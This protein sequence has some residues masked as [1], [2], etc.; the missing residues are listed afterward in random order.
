MVFENKIT[1]RFT[2]EKK[3]GGHGKDFH[4]LIDSA[5]YDAGI[6]RLC[7]QINVKRRP[8]GTSRYTDNWSGTANSSGNEIKISVQQDY[9]NPGSIIISCTVIISYYQADE[10]DL[11]TIREIITRTGLEPE[12]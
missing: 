10:S 12:K 8:Y 11:D 4:K 6:T 5:L 7:K 3:F 9:T 2:I 1:E